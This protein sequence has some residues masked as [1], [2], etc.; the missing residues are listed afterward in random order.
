MANVVSIA[1]RF[2]HSFVSQYADF[3]VNMTKKI[4]ALEKSP[5]EGGTKMK[6][7]RNDDLLRVFYRSLHQN[8]L[9][10]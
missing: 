7:M 10:S 6:K 3:P 2:R 8:L 1:R 9:V 4:M 5:Q